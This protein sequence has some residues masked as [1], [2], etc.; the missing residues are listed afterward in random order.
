MPF[1]KLK[2]ELPLIGI[3]RALIRKKIWTQ[4]KNLDTLNKKKSGHSTKKSD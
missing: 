2:D 4:Q 1:A 3:C